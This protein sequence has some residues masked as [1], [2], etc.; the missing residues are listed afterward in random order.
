MHLGEKYR[1]TPH[2]F[3]GEVGKTKGPMPCIPRMVTGR[4]VYINEAHRYFTVE[5]SVDWA[6]IRE[7]FKFDEYR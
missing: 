1:F 2:A 4:I 6:T 5:A 3:T 7:S